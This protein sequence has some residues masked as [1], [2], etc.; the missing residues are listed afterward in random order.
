[1]SSGSYI[2]PPVR[3]VEIEKDSGGTR[4]RRYEAR[5]VLDGMVGRHQG[6][7]AC[8][9]LAR[10]HEGGD[11]GG[12]G[13]V[14]GRR[15]EHD[16]AWA[17][18]G[19]LGFFLDEEAMVVVADDDGLGEPRLAAEPLQRGRKEARRLVVE[20][21]NELLGV[22]GPRQGPQAVPEPPERIIE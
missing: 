13:R 5:L 14:A 8:R 18:A 2:P 21:A 16:G 17:H 1:M 4:H 6:N 19:A 22:H 10:D 11:R 9:V 3:L 12:R 7:D 15:L 20:E